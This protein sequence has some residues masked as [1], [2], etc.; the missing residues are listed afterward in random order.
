[1]DEASLQRIGCKLASF[2]DMPTST[3][4]QYKEI[5]AA[6]LPRFLISP[7]PNIDMV[8]T[9]TT[10]VHTYLLY[11]IDVPALDFPLHTHDSDTT[12]Q[13]TCRAQYLTAF[14]AG[15]IGVKVLMILK[16]GMCNTS[17]SVDDPDLV[18]TSITFG[19][20]L[21]DWLYASLDAAIALKYR[22]ITEY[23]RRQD[24]LQPFPVQV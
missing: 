3:R 5:I 24:S 16:H 18:A 10:S 19:R 12:L 11:S 4:A 21:R 14:R 15:R 22:T 7:K 13:S 20:L 1:M 23:D 17:E 9:L 8:N 2:S 6:V